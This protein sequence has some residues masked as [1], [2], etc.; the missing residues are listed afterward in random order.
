MAQTRII[1]WEGLF[2][3]AL[4]HA[5]ILRC[6]RPCRDH[7][8]G[9]PAIA[10]HRDR[11]Q[12]ALLWPRDPCPHDRRCGAHGCCLAGRRG[13]GQVM[14]GLRLQGTAA[15]SLLRLGLSGAFGRFQRGWRA[16]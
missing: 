16:L 7:G 15:Q 5:P 3:P 13:E 8:G 14:A 9:W 1:I 12:I 10:R 6:D 11:L 2:D 4:L